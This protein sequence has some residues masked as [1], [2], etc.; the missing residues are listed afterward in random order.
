MNVTR[1]HDSLSGGA[2]AETIVQM[3][4]FSL[5]E[6]ESSCLG[7]IPLS[8]VHVCKWCFGSHRGVNCF[9]QG[10]ERLCVPDKAFMLVVMAVRKT[11]REGDQIVLLHSII[12]QRSLYLL[13]V[14]T[15]RGVSQQ[16]FVL[17]VLDCSQKGSSLQRI[18][19]YF[20][21]KGAVFAFQT[22]GLLFLYFHAA[23]PPP[24]FLCMNDSGSHKSKRLRV[25]FF[26]CRLHILNKD[27]PSSCASQLLAASVR[28]ASCDRHGFVNSLP[29]LSF[30]PTLVFLR[31]THIS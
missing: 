1:V 13:C 16:Y 8:R 25:C 19:I 11:L 3:L 2:T 18:F 9:Q 20:F 28:F 10:T 17:N 5:P 26:T 27:I 4:P 12:H 23:P 22:A 14:W 30:P 29:F 31:A 21:K 6:K 7:L 24:P 15:L